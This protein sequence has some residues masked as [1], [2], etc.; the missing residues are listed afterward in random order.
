MK[1]KEGWHVCRG[2][3]VYINVDGKVCN[4][5]KTDIN[6]NSVP[7]YPYI[8]YNGESGWLNAYGLLSLSSLEARIKRGTAKIA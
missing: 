3:E 6:G 7:A 5:V 4:C 1:A 2:Y 8:S